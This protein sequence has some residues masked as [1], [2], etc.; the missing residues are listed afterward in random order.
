MDTESMWRAVDEGRTRLA[1]LVRPLTAP[2]WA[3]AS[4]CT[5]WTLRDV[6][7]HV[8]MPLMGNGALAAMAL[9]HPGG[10]N[11]LIR[12]GSREIARRHT[13]AQL[14]DRLEQ[15]V[16]NRRTFPGLSVREVHLDLL[17]HTLDIALPL[18]LDPDLPVDHLRVAADHALHLAGGRKGKVFEHL[19]L[20]RVRLQATD[21]DW[22]HGS[23]P[24]VTGAMSDLYL[25]VTGR[26]A[27]LGRVTGPGVAALSP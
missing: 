3:T 9:R 15:L 16:G 23:G 27:G 22:S 12:E 14:V 13:P 8:T 17:A 18:A 25:L 10:S 6:L 26:R 1:G 7:A 21:T 2:Q 24:E 19:P 20:D 11:R 5:G 4:L